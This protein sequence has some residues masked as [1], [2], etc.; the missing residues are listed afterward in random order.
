MKIAVT[1]A[2][3][4][5]G[6]Y[7][8]PR[9]EML[10]HDVT[11][12]GRNFPRELD[13]DVIWHL[14]APDHRNEHEC[15]QFMWFNEDVASTYLP[16]INTGTWW[17]YAGEESAGL[18]YSRIKQAQQTMFATTLVLFSVYGATQRAQRGFIPQLIN[19]ANGHTSLAGASRQQR[20]WIHVEDVFRAYMAAT[21]APVGTYD[22][23][24]GSTLSPH[25]LALA[26]TGRVLPDYAEF[27]NCAPQYVNDR[28]PDWAPKMDVLF[29][30]RSNV[31]QAA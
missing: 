24:T 8:C 22:V 6:S 19:H 2:S 18:Y 13:A 9:L 21:A 3:G 26:V 17:Q 29:Y 23:A 10:G 27:P 1:G 11:R 20:D 16:V 31:Y 14:A 5:L 30:T 25:E 28:L 4:H 7:I 15:A 12:I